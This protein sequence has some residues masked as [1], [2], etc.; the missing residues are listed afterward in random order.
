MRSHIH[1]Q[2]REIGGH[3]LIYL[4]MMKTFG[5]REEC[6]NSNNTNDKKR[7]KKGKNPHKEK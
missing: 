5:T 1:H 4:S 2:V 6:G 3:T 7:Y